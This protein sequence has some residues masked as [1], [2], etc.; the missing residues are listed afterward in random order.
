LFSGWEPDGVWERVFDALPVTPPEATKLTE[1]FVLRLPDGVEVP[2]GPIATRC[3]KV[4]PG[5]FRIAPDKAVQFMRAIFDSRADLGS[6][7][8]TSVSFRAF[9]DAQLSFLAQRTLRVP[10][11]PTSLTLLVWRRE[12]CGKST[13]GPTLWQIVSPPVLSRAE[14]VSV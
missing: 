5:L 7:R 14:A 13:A 2:V 12:I 4:S 9:I 1:N 11:H 3:N 6:L 10:N 8:N